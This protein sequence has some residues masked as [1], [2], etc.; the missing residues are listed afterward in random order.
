MACHFE[1]RDPS[2]NHNVHALITRE[3]ATQARIYGGSSWRDEWYKQSPQ[4]DFLQPQ[5]IMLL[6]GPNR[7][8]LVL[9]V[10]CPT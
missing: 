10:G 7:N 4:A 5:P 1:A 9:R 3:D 2:P 8:Q 6:N